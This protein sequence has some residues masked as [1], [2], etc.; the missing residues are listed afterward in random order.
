[1]ANKSLT[2]V[3]ALLVGAG[4]VSLP[5]KAS[6]QCQLCEPTQQ[7]AGKAQ[8]PIS[9]SVEATLDYSMIG[10]VRPQ[11]GGTVTIDADTGTR[12]L[13]GSL[14]NLGGIPVTG[15]VLIRA[16]PKSHVDVAFPTTVQLRNSSGQTYPL[17]NFTTSLKNN[18][19]VG[20]D[21]TLRFTFGGLLKID[22]SATGTFRG[23]FPITVDYK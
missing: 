12:T 13:T 14:V 1:M 17:S 9:V 10:L 23:S 21:G 7:A 3:A 16:E 20:D 18:P 4:L 6:A 8:A 19:K 22:G 15:T 2:A 11:Q 5:S